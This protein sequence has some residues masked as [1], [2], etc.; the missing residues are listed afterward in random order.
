MLDGYHEV[1]F[2]VVVV[3]PGSAEESLNCKIVARNSVIA[4]EMH[5]G[6]PSRLQLPL[7]VYTYS[8]LS[9]TNLQH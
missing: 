6:D 3:V 5:A 9:M 1:D 8:E 7:Y 2:I 4:C